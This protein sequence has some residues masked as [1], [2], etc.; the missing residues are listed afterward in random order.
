[1]SHK[2]FEKYFKILMLSQLNVIYISGDFKIYFLLPF[3]NEH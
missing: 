2:T 3:T 1:M